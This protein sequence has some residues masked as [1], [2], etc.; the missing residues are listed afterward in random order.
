MSKEATK[1]VIVGGGFGGVKTALN[2]AN[3]PGFD[4]Q[5][6]SDNRWK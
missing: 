6:I 3:K 2:L 1:V 5:L 4:V